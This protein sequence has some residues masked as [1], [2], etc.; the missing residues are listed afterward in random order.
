MRELNADI[1]DT[2][3]VSSFIQGHKSFDKALIRIL[4]LYIIKCL[5]IDFRYKQLLTI[6]DEIYVL[7]KK[8]K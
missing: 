8:S 7:I 6:V 4:K 3:T 5:K 2:R 1:I